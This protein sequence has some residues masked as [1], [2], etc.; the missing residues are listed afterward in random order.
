M[1]QP[2]SFGF[3]IFCSL[4]IANFGVSQS[5]DLNLI[6]NQIIP[7]VDY[8][9]RLSGNFGEIRSSHFHM[10]IDIKQ[11]GLGKEDKIR[12]VAAGHISRIRISPGGYGKAIYIDHPAFGITTVY[13]HLEKF[14]S[15]L[16]KWIRE[17]QQKKQSYSIDTILPPDLFAITKGGWIGILGNTGHS[18]GPHL[19]FEI[20]ETIS[21]NPINPFLVGLKPSDNIKPKI[22]SVSVHG[23]NP[24][25][26]KTCETN[27]TLTTQNIL[28]IEP[29]VVTLPARNAGIAVSTHDLMD[30]A[31]NKNGIYSLRMFVDDSLFY[32]FSFDKLSFDETRTVAGFIDYG[33]KIKED[34]TFMLCYKLPGNDLQMLAQQGSG[35]FQIYEQKSRT[36]RIEVEDFDKNT[37]TAFFY[38][39][40]EKDVIVNESPDWAKILKPGEAKTV[41]FHQGIFLFPEYSVF[42][43]TNLFFT[44]LFAADGNRIYVIKEETE[45]IK[46]PFI[47]KIKPEND[48]SKFKRQA[49]ICH[50]NA[51]DVKS[52]LGGEWEGEYLT[53]THKELGSFYIHIDTIPPSIKSI[54]F[55]TKPTKKVSFSFRMKDDITSK[56]KALSLE[57]G[58]WINDEWVICPYKSMTQKL[59]IPISNLP[60]GEHTLVIRAEDHSG[61]IGEYKGKFIKI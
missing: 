31:E 49:I 19:H 58:V 1:R 54:D 33:V 26:Q 42:R 23:L 35:I 13:A 3:L 32:S 25:F 56:G 28:E 8:P 36:I 27:L 47:I 52:N 12:S 50:I 37:S 41:K 48:I 29:I 18:Y 4:L 46:T 34:M 51:K 22:L 43:N 17:Q 40:G 53:T 15:N 61:N 14:E 44:D 21:E 30:G 5:L 59:E 7:P 39:K 45:P 11:S 55:T 20:R 9:L 10:G 16:E 24:D 6:K 60:K 2:F 57:Y 38:V